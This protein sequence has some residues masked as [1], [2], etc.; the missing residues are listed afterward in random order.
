MHWFDSPWCTT[1]T[2]VEQTQSRERTTIAPNKGR[3]NSIV[4]AHDHREGTR[5]PRGHTTIARLCLAPRVSQP[6]RLPTLPT[7]L[8]ATT[9]TRVL[10]RRRTGIAHRY[11]FLV[12]HIT[13]NGRES[14]PGTSKVQP[15]YSMLLAP[16]PPFCI[17]PPTSP[18]P[19]RCSTILADVPPPWIW[20]RSVWCSLSS[21]RL[22]YKCACR[23]SSPGHKH[24]GLV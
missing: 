17:P 24:G 13:T 1:P 16:P 20:V 18:C 5:P 21:R 15:S 10:E 7:R 8:S 3:A 4:R 23:E 14:R 22:Q 2:K 12:C 9:P 6:A 19:S 11:D